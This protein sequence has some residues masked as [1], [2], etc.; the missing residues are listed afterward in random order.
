MASLHVSH[1]RSVT[2]RLLPTDPACEPQLM[3]TTGPT[4]SSPQASTA[5]GRAEGPEPVGSFG[6]GSG[7]HRDPAL[8][9]PSLRGTPD[10]RWRCF[11]PTAVKTGSV[12]ESTL[13]ERS[14]R[15]RTIHGQNNLLKQ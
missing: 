11:R 5:V 9:R 6:M 4:R 8:R 3:G 14:Q 15:R 10:R 12:C 2:V 7:G 13:T 1:I